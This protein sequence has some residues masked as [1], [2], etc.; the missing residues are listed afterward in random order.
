M[1]SLEMKVHVFSPYLLINPDMH[2]HD[3]L[4][5]SPSHTHTHTQIYT[6]THTIIFLS[7]KQIL[8]SDVHLVKQT[9]T[10]IQSLY[11][12]LKLQQV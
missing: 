1:I 3:S 4:T 7:S 5:L 11:M 12:Y 10:H 2:A 8:S 9:Q 6:N